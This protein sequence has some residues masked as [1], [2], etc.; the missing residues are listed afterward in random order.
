MTLV[1]G[2]LR[3]DNILFTDK[4]NREFYVR[5]ANCSSGASLNDVAYCNTTHPNDRAG[6]EEELVKE[7][8]GLDNNDIILSNRH[9]MIIVEVHS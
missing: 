5:L 1:Q 8:H 9:G 2:D 3:L 4:N 6:A 7:Y